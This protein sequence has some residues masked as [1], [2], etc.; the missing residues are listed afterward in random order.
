M[1]VTEGR[2]RLLLLFFTTMRYHLI[3]PLIT[4]FLISALSAGQPP[5]PEVIYQQVRYSCVTVITKEKDNSKG[6]GSGFIYLRPG[7]VATAWHVVEGS[8]AMRVQFLGGISV[9]V[10]G[11]VDKDVK[12]DVAI[13]KLARAKGNPL[14]VRKD[15]PPVGSKVYS[16]GAPDEYEFSFYDGMLNQIREGKD[17]YI[18]Q[19]SCPISPGSSGAPIM[20]ESGQVCGLVSYMITDCQNLNFAMPICYVTKLNDRLPAR[21]W[22]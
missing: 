2:L 13:L 4:L 21:K 22:D 19:V 12:H 10:V 1:T 3:I 15:F 7:L 18:L 14:K 11:L 5:K 9:P 6:T 17:G 16:L 20:D 8:K